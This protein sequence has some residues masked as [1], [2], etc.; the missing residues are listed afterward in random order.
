MV[1]KR[2]KSLMFLMLLLLGVGQT[3]QATRVYA[4]LSK[5]IAI[6]NSK[7]EATT[8]TYT[9]TQNSYASMDLPGL[10]GDMRGNKLILDLGAM[11]GGNFRVDIQP[12]GSDWLANRKGTIVSPES[13]NSQFTITLDD[14]FTE[15]ELS[16][17]KAIRVNQS[18]TNGSVVLNAIYLEKPFELTFDNNGK[19]YIDP[20]DMIATG[21]NLD[22]QTGVLT[23]AGTEAASLSVDFGDMDFSNV[24]N[25]SVEVDYSSNDYTDLLKSNTQ[26]I[27][28]DNNAVQTWTASR[29]SYNPPSEGWGDVAH[30]KFFVLNMDESKEGSMQIKSIC[31][32]KNLVTGMLGNEVC[33]RDLPFYQVVT[34]GDDLQV[35]PQW[36]MNVETAEVYGNCIDVDN[37]SH[38]TDLSIYEEIHVYQT[39]GENNLRFW[40]FNA[41]KSDV[42]TIFPEIIEGLDY[43]VIKIADVKAQ[44][45]GTA[46]LEGCKSD[47]Y[48][49]EGHGGGKVTINNITVT[50]P[51]GVGDYKLTGYGD[52]DTKAQEFLNDPN[53]TL[54]NATGI[55]KTM[56]LVSANPNCLFIANEGIL[57]NEN[58]V[59]IAD[60]NPGCYTCENLVL[61]VTK[62]FRIPG[63]ITTTNA[64]AKKSVSEAGYATMVLPF[65]V[66]VPER[67]T[68][69]KLTSVEGEKVMGEA[70]ANIPAGQ[71]VLLKADAADYTFKAT[72]ATLTTNQQPGGEGLLTGVYADDYAPAGS[73]VLQNNTEGVAFYNVENDNAQ[74][75]VQYT[76]YLTL[77]ETAQQ[78][79]RLIFALGEDDVTGIESVEAAAEST[80]TVVEIYDLSGRQ[81]SAPVKGINLMKMSDGSVK[82]V[83]VR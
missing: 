56:T 65:A 62:P 36:N 72:G 8:N 27:N 25:I 23:K 1:H 51:N 32:T 5:G 59:L 53:A 69:Y 31:I 28:I 74:K 12:V 34:D 40:F 7:W 11:T 80:A 48:N 43:S 22:P 42:V 83:I 45:G 21:M 17:V 68:A 73:Y 77:P 58:N 15:E 14:I 30:V 64:S 81:V 16:N 26:L 75:V 2:L 79:N 44:C 13:A 78:A 9:W 82:K 46:Y 47:E 37:C 35:T 52:L 49:N 70:L 24:A 54:I 60:E 3:A 67:V 57:A 20:S 71:P 6:G 76:A 66:S 61:D 38:Y 33:L 10:V 4:D 41:D 18:S 39:T 50:D 55:T 19:A 29:Y 63:T